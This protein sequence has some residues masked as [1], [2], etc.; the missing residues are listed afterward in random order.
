MHKV[1]TVVL[2]SGKLT[3]VSSEWITC[4][5]E[6]AHLFEQAQFADAQKPRLAP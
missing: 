3:E 2:A 6:T 5:A 4:S 1:L